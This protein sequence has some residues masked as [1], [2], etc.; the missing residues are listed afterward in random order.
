MKLKIIPVLVLLSVIICLPA[1]GQKKAKKIVLS[2]Y[3]TDN[4]GKPV[5]GAMILIDK[6]YSNIQTDDKGFY[7]L[8]IKPDAKLLTVFTTKTGNEVVG[9]NGRTSINIKLGGSALNQSPATEKSDM[10]DIG[11]A[12]SDRKN[13]TS[14]VNKIDATSDKYASYPNIY[15]MLRGIVPG[16]Q[17]SGKTI[18]IQGVNSANGRTPPLFVVDGNVVSSIDDIV[19]VQVK[20]IEVL[21]GASASIYGSRGQNGVIL[22][23]LKGI[24]D[25]K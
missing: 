16:V 12:T 24:P 3:V 6:K 2:G 20:S 10:V 14:Q 22:I 1:A 18:T 19:P 13:A 8:K 25:N 5:Q 11:Y 9:I 23:H 15:E 21:K 4:S 7:R 17:V